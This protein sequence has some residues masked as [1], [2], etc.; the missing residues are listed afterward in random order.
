[1][2]LE[3][4]TFKD[5]RKKESYKEVEIRSINTVDDSNYY[6]VFIG[7]NGVG[8]TRIFEGIIKNILAEG[9]LFRSEECIQNVNYSGKI[10]KIIFSTYTLFNRELSVFSEKYDYYRTNFNSKSIVKQVSQIYFEQ[11]LN[12]GEEQKI[13]EVL[14]HVGKILGLES[15]PRISVR[16]ITSLKYDILIKRVRNLKLDRPSVLRTNIQE[17]KKILPLENIEIFEKK[18]TN[19]NKSSVYNQFQKYK[20]KFDYLDSLDRKY[21]YLSLLTV[22]S[23]LM[24]HRQKYQ[25]SMKNQNI[26]NLSELIDI[27]EQ[28]FEVGFETAKELLRIDYNIAKELEIGFVDDLAFFNGNDSKLITQFSSGEFAFFTRLLELAVNIT[29]NSLVLIDEPETF[30]NPKWVFEFVNLL[31]NLF[32]NKSCHF[33]IASQSPFVV[34]SV[35]REDIIK[36]K[37]SKDDRILFEYEENQTLGATVNSILSDVFDIGLEDNIVFQEYKDL[38]VKKSQNNFLESLK[39]LSNLADS[40]EKLELMLTLST[41]ANK[42]IVRQKIEEIERERFG[43]E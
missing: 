29:D 41:E 30:L 11:K 35:K 26:Y 10:E 20:N 43:S 1:M 5:L 37:K 9:S 15:E 16:G 33:I 27:Y 6:T 8:K 24:Y 14:K 22:K 3:T 40:S 34:G 39:L 38:I 42:E 13:L 2:K 25:Y 12:N 7:E 23:M 19:F 32:K 4:F 31:K 28:Y 18:L 36:I 17:R 21:C